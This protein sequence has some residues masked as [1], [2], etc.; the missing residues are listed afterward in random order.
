MKKPDRLPELNVQT[1]L[2]QQLSV[3]LRLRF[4]L[5][6]GVMLLL[7]GPVYPVLA[8]SVL[9]PTQTKQ[10]DASSQHFSSWSEP[11]SLSEAGWLTVDQI[12]AK[13]FV[14][15]DRTSGTVL[16]GQ[17]ESSIQFPASTTKIMT[18]LIAL[19]NL[20][21]DQLLT[22]SATALDLPSD[23]AR[24]G[25]VEG[26]IISVRDTLAAMMLRSGNE[27]ANMV[28]EAVSGSQTLFAARMNHQTRLLGL[29]QTHFENAHG[30]HDREHQTTALEIARIAAAA[31]ENPA[32]RDLVSTPVY[33]LPATNKHPYNGWNFLTSTNLRLLLGES[34][35]YQSELL[36]SITGIKT[37]TTAAAGQCL[38]SSA[39]TVEGQ[40]LIAVLLG[41]Q[42]NDPEGNLVVYSRALLEAGASKASQ[43]GLSPA[44]QVH[45]L[46]NTDSDDSLPQPDATSQ[47]TSP[48][49][50]PVAAAD[51]HQQSLATLL[52]LSD[53]PFWQLAA[54]GGAGLLLI[55]VSWL[56][57]YLAGRRSWRR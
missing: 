9:Q 57:G 23:A 34:A 1:L 40:E 2:R 24:A 11:G 4:S 8:D 6:L 37:G 46:A 49:K 18:A 28:A 51:G 39:I 16:I 50:I 17:D 5:L 43:L 33:A 13:A 7:I 45:E 10:P 41:V 53:W 25:L 47:N 20:A 54:I 35:N 52:T 38:V 48:V 19:E 42:G 36:L 27:A 44:F 29:Q 21:P 12:K 15:I 55:L 26:E 56:F 30:L 3:A 31:M 22:V 32:F 14:V